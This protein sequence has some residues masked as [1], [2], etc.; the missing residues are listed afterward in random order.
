MNSKFAV[1]LMVKNPSEVLT[2]ISSLMTQRNFV[3]D[4]F[5]L[6]ETEKSGYARVTITI[7][8]DEHQREQL[9]KQLSKLYDVKNAEL[10]E[11]DNT[12]MRELMIVKVNT[13][14]RLREVLDTAAV[15]KSKIL[16]MSPSSVCME[17]TGETGK[18][19]A[20]LN[21]I[22]DYGILECCRTGLVALERGT[23]CLFDTATA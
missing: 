16:D 21:C 1:S 2:R 22:R 15:Y 17:L 6:G 11:P 9:L 23:S 4:T 12:I 8:G 18:L 14:G 10:L 20:F 19:D 5:S 3:I 7:K 13:S